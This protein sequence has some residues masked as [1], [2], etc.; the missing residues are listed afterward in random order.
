MDDNSELDADAFFGGFRF[1]IGSPDDDLYPPDHP[2][3]F[4]LYVVCSLLLVVL[5]LNSLIAIMSDTSHFI[6]PFHSVLASCMR[7]P[8]TT[9]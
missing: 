1:G 2:E 7:V 4:L 9:A 5:V 8:R 6:S 3:L